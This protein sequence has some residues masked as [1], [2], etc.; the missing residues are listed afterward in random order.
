MIKHPLH[1]ILLSAVPARR[2]NGLSQAACQA[3]ADV[4]GR[5]YLISGIRAWFGAAHEC[6]SFSKLSWKC[7]LC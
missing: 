5:R 1:H 7:E 3:R 2:V 6:Q 4:T